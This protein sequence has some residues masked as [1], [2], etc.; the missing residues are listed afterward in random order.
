MLDKTSIVSVLTSYNAQV[1]RFGACS[2]ELYNILMS[3]FPAYTKYERKLV[4]FSF[5]NMPTS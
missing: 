3:D 4:S 1:G 5:R 2:Y